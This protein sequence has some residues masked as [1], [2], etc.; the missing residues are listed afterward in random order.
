M[1]I[2]W[3]FFSGLLVVIALIIG[4]TITAQAK[5]AEQRDI[6]DFVNAQGTLCIGIPPNCF[7]IV[8]PLENFLGWEDPD[9]GLLASIDYAGIA[10]DYLEGSLD[11]TFSGQITERLL[12][13]GR[14]HV[15][16]ILHTKNA[17]TWATD[18]G[19]FNNN[20]LFGYRA[21]DIMAGYSPALCDSHLKLVFINAAPHDPVP[22]LIQLAFFPEPEQELLSLQIECTTDGTASGAPAKI[23]VSLTGAFFPSASAPE[24]DGFPVEKIQIKLIRH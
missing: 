5:N 7:L 19:D 4:N 18:G 23:I 8:P 6:M 13:D 1:K 16:V 20:L 2:Y 14:A 21:P 22:D 3:Q 24:W 12:H 15:S 9:S 11:T 10:D 17:L